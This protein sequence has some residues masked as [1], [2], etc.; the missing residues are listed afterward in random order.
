M[1]LIDS[2]VLFII[3]NRPDTTQ[4][5]FEAIK[6]AKP[7]KLYVASDGPR[8]D[9]PNDYEKVK[10]A[11]M[12][13]DQIDWNCELYT[14][15]E[16]KNLG[17]GLGESSAMS[18]VFETEDR[19]II[20]EDDTLPALSFFYY[21]DEL[22]EQY[23]ND[24]RIWMI[25]GN[26]FDEEVVTTPHSYFFSKYGHYWGWATWKRCWQEYDIK[27]KKYPL[28]LEQNLVTS[29][30]R[31]EKE[32]LFFNKKFEEYFNKS[33]IEDFDTWDYQFD[34]ALA[35]NSHI[36]ILPTKN[37]VKN[38]GY[39]G[40]H[41]E[42]KHRLHDRAIDENYKIISHPDFILCD[43]NYDANHFKNHWMWKSPFSKRVIRKMKKI[44]NLKEVK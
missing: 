16:D 40:V 41:T 10:Q 31:T 19:A 3:F 29:L 18:W 24:T 17:C 12:I 1:K 4:K 14:K 9:V 25:S 5:V 2:P 15:F 30:F 37:L 42:R 6:K 34:F 11:R 21:C 20:I 33:K 36:C 23:K 43:T 28:L 44:L 35:I 8:T 22:L 7:T 39:A 32:A 27:M 13:I 38:I 26:Q